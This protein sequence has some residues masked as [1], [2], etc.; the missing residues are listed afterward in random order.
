MTNSEQ[1]A[2]RRH[3]EP[4]ALGSVLGYAAGNVFDRLAVKHAD[5]LI[6]PFLRGL[7]SLILGVVLVWKNRTL[8]QLQRR[9][10]DF[11]GGRAILSF[12][13][14][15]LLSTIGLFV[16]YFAIRVGGL[17]VTI[18]V[19]ETWVIW[20][21][22]GAWLFL[23]ERLRGLML[24]GWAL[25]ALG[26]GALIWGQLRG[27]PISPY[28]YWAIPLAGLTAISYGVSGVLWRD[29]QLRGAHQSTA[30]LVH[31]VTS[32][33]V[34]VLGLVVLGRVALILTTAWRDALALLTSGVLS[35]IIAVYCIFTALRLME[36]ARVY[37]F[38]SLTPLVATL[39]AHF[40]LREH[41]NLL[42]LLGVLLISAGVSLT[43]IFQPKAERGRQDLRSAE[44]SAP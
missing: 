19:V 10:A 17:I 37:A 42:I 23:R 1:S 34:S 28:W 27:Q 31:F 6:G 40:F 8:G 38:S 44:S 22:L 13:W 39:F 41:L 33:A 5:P 4:W 15:G 20:G 36:V 35:G 16:Y 14:A 21:T 18:P 11:V 9:S 32:V 25:I 30:I 26:L 29:G 7:P 2:G 12:V 3:G 43:Q 24:A